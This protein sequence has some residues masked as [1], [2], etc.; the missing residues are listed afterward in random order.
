[1]PHLSNL[2]VQQFRNLGL[3][4]ITPSP[5]LNL[6]YGENGSGKTSLLEAI[7]VLAHCRSFRTHK[8]RRLIQ[9]TTTAFTVFATV[10]GSDAFKVGVQRE[11]SG[12]ST[13]RLDGLSAKSSAQL[14]T[15]L[16]VQI[17]DAHTFALL[18][19]GSKARRKFYDWLV[20]HVKHD[21][22]T[23]WANYV[24][25][26]KQR[27]SL[28]R[29]DKIAYSDLRPWDEQITG[30]AATID[31]CRVECITPLIQAFKALMGE[32]KF[33]DNVDLTLAYQ[34]GWKEGEL[35]FPQ[36]LEQA[37]A[38]DRKLGYTTLG[39]HKSDLK[40]TAN[41]SP[42]VEV[43]SRGQQKAVINALHIAE[44]QVY[45]TQ[46]GRTPVFLLDDMPS[47]LDANHI[48]ILSGWLSN[49]GA[50]IFVTGVDANKL[51]AVWPLQK[52][53]VIKMFHVKQ[54]EVTVSQ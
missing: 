10:E 17:I 52:N 42:A 37:F 1:M 53:E 16:P 29:H 6:V 32:C 28:L 2:K 54:G 11:W 25:C 12:K 14:A 48:A 15:N 35:S 30:L 40:I 3:V 9:D 24:K 26:V 36:Q 18:E 5:T 38:R 43:L 22:K 34:P 33:A 23:A 41:G 27:N 44:A 49:L 47:E 20:F 13:A 19:G 50:Q 4:D 7:S 51:A 31:E 46:I 8:Y 21:F 39:P 45:K